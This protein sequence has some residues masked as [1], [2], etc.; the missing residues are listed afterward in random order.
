MIIMES[1]LDKFKELYPNLFEGVTLTPK[2]IEAIESFPVR[3]YELTDDIKA[4]VWNLIGKIS[5]V[6]EDSEDVE[7]KITDL[8]ESYIDE[9]KAYDFYCQERIK[10]IIGSYFPDSPEIIRIIGEIK[11]VFNADTCV[12]TQI[13]IKAQ[14]AAD[15][16]IDSF[17]K[18]EGDQ[19]TFKDIT[20]YDIEAFAKHRFHFYYY[21]LVE[22]FNP[23]CLQFFD[24]GDKD[25]QTCLFSIFLPR[26][27]SNK[28][29]NRND[30]YVN[31][32]CD[33]NMVK[34]EI[35]YGNESIYDVL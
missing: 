34:I 17:F 31:L 30:T 20:T 18:K 4:N 6:F 5:P 13:K 7:Y 9:S 25:N 22:D 1:Q 8:I 14:K 24:L 3:L 2:Q 11:D 32:N 27:G 19:Y 35:R 26:A 12:Y 16:I 33:T 21:K 10:R 23:H 15:D 29:I 28:K